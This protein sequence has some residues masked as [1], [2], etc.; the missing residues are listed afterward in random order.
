M[1][2]VT[3]LTVGKKCP[4]LV[5]TNRPMGT[6]ETFTLSIVTSEIKET[7]D[8]ETKIDL[9]IL[10]EVERGEPTTQMAVTGTGT[11]TLRTCKQCTNDL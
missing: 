11:E 3:G 2:E 10:A 6:L 7:V 8:G 1:Y 5:S 4:T 9:L